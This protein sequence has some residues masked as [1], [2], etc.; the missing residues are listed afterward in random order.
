MIPPQAIPVLGQLEVL[1]FACMNLWSPKILIIYLMSAIS[2][3]RL[4]FNNCPWDNLNNDRILTHRRLFE[5]NSNNGPSPGLC[6]LGQM[7]ATPVQVSHLWSPGGCNIWSSAPGLTSIMAQEITWIVAAFWPRRLFESNSIYGLSPSHS[8]L[9][10][11]KI[12]TACNIAALLITLFF[13]PKLLR[14]EL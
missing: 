11:R 13:P 7:K 3:S 8:N 10:T 6:N 9:G 12:T 14:G 4:H 1:L 5:C 2:G